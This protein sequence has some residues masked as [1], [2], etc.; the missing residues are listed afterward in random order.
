MIT[1]EKVE[2]Q[3]GSERN[4]F[5]TWIRRSTIF[6]KFHWPYF[7][8]GRQCLYTLY[9]LRYG[10]SKLGEFAPTRTLRTC[11]DDKE[12]KDNFNK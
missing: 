10:R 2:A 1:N 11:T 12:N 6:P 5:K 3:D 7:C 8:S 9:M 4:K